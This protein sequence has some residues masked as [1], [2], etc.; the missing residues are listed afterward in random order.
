MSSTRTFRFL[1]KAKGYFIF[2]HRKNNIQKQFHITYIFCSKTRNWNRVSWNLQYYTINTIRRTSGVFEW[3]R[4]RG[5]Y[6]FLRVITEKNESIVTDVVI[7]L[8]GVGL[9]SGTIKYNS[10]GNSRKRIYFRV[11]LSTRYRCSRN[12]TKFFG[13]VFSLYFAIFFFSI[14]TLP[15]TGTARIT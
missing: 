14:I 10:F 15:T 4:G 13:F 1:N 8:V 11:H 6:K 3:H 12:E 2:Y 5:E 9:S 7:I